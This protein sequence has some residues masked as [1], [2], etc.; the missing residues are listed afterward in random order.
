MILRPASSSRDASGG[1]R[2]LVVERDEELARLIVDIVVDAGL[3]A[4]A[5]KDAD[6]ARDL[7][8]SGTIDLLIVGVS[9][10]DIRDPDAAHP[11]R[12]APAV[13]A[14]VMTELGNALPFQLEPGDEVLTMPFSAGDVIARAR[15]LLRGVRLAAAAG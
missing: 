12:R 3:D 7:L 9:L 15:R 11:L 8:A 10:S 2:V 14:I 4:R 6:E 13:P 1:E 5:V